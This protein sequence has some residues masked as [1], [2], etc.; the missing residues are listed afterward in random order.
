MDKKQLCKNCN[1]KILKSAHERRER[2][3]YD[4]ILSL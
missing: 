2:M 1:I 3:C 4:C